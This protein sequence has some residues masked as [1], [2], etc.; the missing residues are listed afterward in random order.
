MH[1][2]QTIHRRGRSAR[3]GHRALWGMKH[4]ASKLRTGDKTSKTP[5]SS[6]H[7]RSVNIPRPLDP[8]RSTP[9]RHENFS[10]TS[11]GGAG[12]KHIES[13]QTVP[14]VGRR[15]KSNESCHQRLSWVIRPS[16]CWNSPRRPSPWKLRYGHGLLHISSTSRG[17][18]STWVMLRGNHLQ[19]AEDASNQARPP[20]EALPLILR[21]R[22][23]NGR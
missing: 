13:V 5:A 18:N 4:G 9:C 20:R 10:E 12:G 11:L 16:S 19:G 7:G 22:G 15:R 6:L 17:E 21:S 14:T 3:D 23:K 2:Q 1:N 8:T